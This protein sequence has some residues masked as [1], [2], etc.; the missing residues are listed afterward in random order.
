MRKPLS[1]HMAMVEASNQRVLIDKASSV[2][3]C[4]RL[5]RMSHHSHR[6]LRKKLGA[7]PRDRR[8]DLSE[9]GGKNS[10]V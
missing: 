1:L 8:E 6:L 3:K 10:G 5:A 2:P 4:V 9:I 7:V